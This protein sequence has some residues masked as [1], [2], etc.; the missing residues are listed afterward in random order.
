MCNRLEKIMRRIVHFV[1]FKL[2]DAW[3]SHLVPP[4]SYKVVEVLDYKLKVNLQDRGLSRDIL[5]DGIREPQA[6]AIVQRLV[7]DGM[8]ALDIGANIGYYTIM[9]SKLVGKKG[10]VCAVEPIA[11]NFALL[12]ENIRLNSAQNVRSY[13]LALSEKSGKS[14]LFVSKQSNLSSMNKNQYTRAG[15]V[16]VQCK[17]LDDFIE[18]FCTGNVDFIKM[19]VEGHE[20][21]ILMS[22]K[23]IQQAKNLSMF[24]EIHPALIGR[25]KTNELLKHLKKS[26]F[27]L[28]IAFRDYDGLQ[29]ALGDRI[30]RPVD[31]FFSIDELLVSEE[32]ISGKIP[33]MECFFVKTA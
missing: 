22:S 6:T 21:E 9:F 26:G 23:K 24:V 17:S 4:G 31:G 13:Q 18:G 2:V 7:K 33:D 32:F 28:F 12:S 20:Y 1:L 14:T 29:E 27:R 25:I 5:F 30:Y 10:E 8:R 3:R 19:D 11:K 16:E 15:S